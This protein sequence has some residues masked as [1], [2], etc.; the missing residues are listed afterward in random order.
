MIRRN[1]SILPLSIPNHLAEVDFFLFIG[2][3]LA[4]IIFLPKT[5]I[6]FPLF[7]AS[8]IA[9]IVGVLDDKYDLSRYWRFVINI[10]C[11]LIIVLAGISPPFITS[12]FGG[13][14]HLDILRWTFY[15]FGKHSI[16]VWSDLIAIIWIVW[17][18]NMLNWSKGVDGQMPGV[19]AIAAFVIG[20][21]S[22]RFPLSDQSQPLSL[23]N[24]HLLLPVRCLDF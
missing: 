8:L 18:M 22:L 3:W 16:I 1:I 15:F 17:V 7:I 23:R 4:S 19:V 5:K 13:I 10:F 2:T 9:V 12:P 11:A 6:L 14:L 24:Y 20:I 21:L